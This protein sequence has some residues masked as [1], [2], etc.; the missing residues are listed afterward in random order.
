MR[1]CDA[2]IDV[3]RNHQFALV[4]QEG[5]WDIIESAI[6]KQAKEALLQSQETIV[7]QRDQIANILN[8]MV[9]GIYIVNQQLRY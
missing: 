8:S 4:K 7:E 9:D 1:C 2:V 5:K 6:Y 3:I